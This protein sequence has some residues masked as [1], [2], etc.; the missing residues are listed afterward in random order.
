MEN[1]NPFPPDDT[2]PEPLP[3]APPETTEPEPPADEPEA[4]A[5]PDV[6]EDAQA[7]PPN[8]YRPTSYIGTPD[9]ERVAPAGPIDVSKR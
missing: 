3:D 9:P 4:A 1:P 8:T 7:A 2:S 5:E 6:A